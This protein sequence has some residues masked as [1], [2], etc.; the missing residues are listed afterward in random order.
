MRA[1]KLLSGAH[2]VTCEIHLVTCSVVICM[3]KNQPQLHD[4]VI[5]QITELL[6]MKKYCQRDTQHSMTLW[7]C[8]WAARAKSEQKSQARLL[9]VGCS[10]YEL[11]RQNCQCHAGLSFH[12]LLSPSR[13]HTRQRCHALAVLQ[14]CFHL[15][16]S[17]T[18]IDTGLYH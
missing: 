13:T 9:C 12:M 11:K 10:G 1:R 5:I 4:T 7:S 2:L 6:A 3:S 15:G 16:C 8:V 14:I 18:G 17:H